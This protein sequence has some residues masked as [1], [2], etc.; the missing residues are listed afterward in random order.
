MRVLALDAA[1][2][3]CS[4][5][6]VEGDLRL[7][8]RQSDD[9]RGASAA[10]PGMV[11]DVLA[12]SPGGFAAVAVTV[13]PGSF[14]GVRAALALAHG[15]AL[16]A[17]VPIVGVSSIEAI[18]A[19]LPPQ[20]GR[21][22][23]VA[24]DTRRGRVFLGRGDRIDVTPLAALPATGGPVLVGGDAAEDVAAALAERG[25]D[26]MLAGISRI[27]ACDVGRVGA[28]RLAGSMAPLAALPLYVEPPE[29]R[30]QPA[31]RPTPA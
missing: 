4:V 5:G 26:V 30:P 23:W 29:A 11:A 20:D 1:L 14:T 16:G 10:L 28:Q 12:E 9:P 27:D 6:L 17:G 13:G 22:V 2:G 3:P 21:A 19:A 8:Q 24:L 7:A 18:A 31:L 25:E 15:L